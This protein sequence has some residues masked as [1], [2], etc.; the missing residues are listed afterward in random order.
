MTPACAQKAF[1]ALKLSVWT[2][3]GCASNGVIG[4]SL[5]IR[6]ISAKDAGTLADSVRT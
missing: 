5:T 6:A 3:D 2:A 4:V 1:M